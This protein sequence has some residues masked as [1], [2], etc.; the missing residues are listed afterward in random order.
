MVGCSL[1]WNVTL[2]AHSEPR[3]CPSIQRCRTAPEFFTSRIR[4]RGFRAKVEGVG[5]GGH[6]VLKC[7]F[8]LQA[9]AVGVGSLDDCVALCALGTASEMA[10]EARVKFEQLYKE[11]GKKDIFCAGLTENA[12][13][14]PG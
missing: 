8:H 4:E 10:V 14:A 6:K 9:K 12:R 2:F 11:Y 3:P 5:G 7:L 13:G 1:D